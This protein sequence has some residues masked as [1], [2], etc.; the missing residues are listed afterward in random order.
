[1]TP[2]A[3][4]ASGSATRRHGADHAGTKLYEGPRHRIEV[5]VRK[6]H[7]RMSTAGAQMNNRNPTSLTEMRMRVIRRQRRRRGA[8]HDP[9]PAASVSWATE[10]RGRRASRRPVSD[11]AAASDRSAANLA[12]R[13]GGPV[14]ETGARTRTCCGSVGGP[15]SPVRRRQR[16]PRG[17]RGGRTMNRAP[18]VRRAG[19][20]RGRLRASPSRAKACARRERHPPWSAGIRS[21]HRSPTAPRCARRSFSTVVGIRARTLRFL[22]DGRL[23]SSGRRQRRKLVQ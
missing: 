21:D 12:V 7:S 5:A 3:S 19:G 18:S 10:R 4:P 13:R 9:P 20:A 15:P 1:M 11:P 2:T 8:V 22:L 6:P 14:R 23:P 17:C 16:C